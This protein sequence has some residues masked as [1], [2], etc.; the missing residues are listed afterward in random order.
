[1]TTGER[2]LSISTL[3]SGT[4]LDLFLNISGGTGTT[5]NYPKLVYVDITNN[6][7]VGV[8][9]GQLEITASGGTQP[10]TYSIGG[11]YQSS[12]LFV[13]LS[14]G[15]Y[16]LF[17]KDSTNLIDGVGGIKLTSPSAIPTAIIPYIFSLIISDVTNKTSLDG[18]I[19]VFASGGT[20]PY[21]YSLNDNPYQVSDTFTGLPAGNYVINVKDSLNQVGT[22]S[23]VKVS[24]Q[25]IVT[26]GGGYGGG[27]SIAT[28]KIV[29][30]NNVK[31]SDNEINENIKVR[32]I[33]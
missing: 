18:S 10:Y 27:R 26:S 28:R 4:A 19:Q 7:A 33:I 1:M 17:V 23:G 16:N 31:V 5:I 9:D 29:K 11:V 6:S 8:D 21:T 14:T 2:L 30:V 15:T 22:L 24:A 25:T 12:N 32:V 20:S 13:G 3:N